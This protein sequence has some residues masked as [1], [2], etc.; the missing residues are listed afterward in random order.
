MH[1]LDTLLW[2]VAKLVTFGPNGWDLPGSKFSTI[3]VPHVSLDS[4]RN[5][6]ILNCSTQDCTSSVAMYMY[7]PRSLLT[8]LD[9]INIMA[10]TTK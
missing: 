7:C 6:T 8:K 3:H 1:P 5:S 2:K 4:L 9:C 10:I